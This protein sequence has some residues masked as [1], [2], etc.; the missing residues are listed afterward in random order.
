[1]I[2]I[3]RFVGVFI[4][5]FPPLCFSQTAS[6]HSAVYYTYEHGISAEQSQS[7]S[8]TKC[9]GQLKGIGENM[10]RLSTNEERKPVPAAE[11]DHFCL[12]PG[13]VFPHLQGL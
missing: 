8:C 1:M 12:E 3:N 7:G 9:E 13:L 4:L 6:S 5:S 10:G 2:I 11:A